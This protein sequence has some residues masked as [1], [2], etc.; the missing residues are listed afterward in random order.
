MSITAGDRVQFNY[1]VRLADG[2]TLET[3][4]EEDAVITLGDGALP[5]F[6]ERALIGRKTG[7]RF[8]LEISKS[9]D[10]FGIAESRN[11]QSVP[12]SQFTDELFVEPG[13]LVEFQLPD[14]EPVA[15]RI[16][17]INSDVALVDFNH[18]LV[19]KDVCYEIRIT[20]WQAGG[21]GS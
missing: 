12:L 5:E 9:D 17:S 1:E 11:V 7:D 15:G 20:G 2:Q 19:G 13:S 16:V 21:S 6:L 18:P 8:Q 14:G 3:S 4:G 10:V